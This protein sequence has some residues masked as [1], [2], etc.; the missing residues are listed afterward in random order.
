MKR[1]K[2]I[3]IVLFLIVALFVISNN[4]G[5]VFGINLDNITDKLSGGTANEI[6]A[7]GTLIYSIINDVA[8]VVSVA[9]IAFLGVKYMVGSVEER[10]EYKKSMLPYL[11]GA[12]FV[13]GATTITNIVIKMIG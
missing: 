6:K 3:R 12:V 4:I 2:K 10:A 5:V 1:I 7:I 9:V 13:F 8:I 11:I